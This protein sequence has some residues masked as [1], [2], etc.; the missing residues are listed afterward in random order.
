MGESPWKFES[1]RPHQ[2]VPCRTDFPPWSGRIHSNLRC[3]ISNIWG[4][5]RRTGT[6]KT[7]RLVQRVIGGHGY[8]GL[9]AG[10][11]QADSGVR[12]KGSAIGHESSIGKT[13]IERDHLAAVPRTVCGFSDQD[14]TAI[15]LQ[16]ES[17]VLGRGGTAPRYQQIDPGLMERTTGC[18]STKCSSRT[19]SCG[20]CTGVSGLSSDRLHRARPRSPACPSSTTWRAVQ[21]CAATASPFPQDHYRGG[22]GCL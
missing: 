19:T 10:I 9:N 16:R 11:F 13:A 7:Q 3:R 18:G 6:N 15:S 21:R 2:T 5:R 1:S 12:I 17:E 20:T 22:P 14:S 4:R 8:V